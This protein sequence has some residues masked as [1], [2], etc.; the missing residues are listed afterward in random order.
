MYRQKSFSI[1]KPTLYLVPT[2]IGNLEDMT[3]RS[4]RILKEVEVIFAEDTRVSQKVLSHYEI[5]KPLK[6]YHE[7]NKIAQTEEI[8]TYLRKSDSVALISDAGMPLISDPGFEIVLAARSE[9]F[10]VV[11]L[12]GANAVLTGLITSG[13]QTLPFSFFGFLE[14]KKTKRLIALNDLKYRQETLVFYET[15]HRINEVLVDMLSVLGNRKIT[16]ARELTKT[17]E[18]VIHG[19]IEECISLENLKGEMVVIVEGYQQSVSDN[20][21][22]SI[23]DQIDFFIEEGLS[24]TEAMKKVSSL[25]GIP[26]NKIYQEYL[27]LVVKK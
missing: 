7:H 6:S 15:P 8:L 26:K 11:S 22:L 18:E 23:V 21:S 16:I 25:T 3:F 20:Q 24:K 19:T 14:A 2:P 27:E 12:P 17:F 4:L 13:I 10:N 5:K 1:E 9:R